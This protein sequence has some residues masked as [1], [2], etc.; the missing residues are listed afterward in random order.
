MF[1]PP[2]PMCLL[3]PNYPLSTERLILECYLALL[4]IIEHLSDGM[5]NSL[6]SVVLHIF[7]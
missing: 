3:S 1:L 7:N 6:D 4:Q 2:L 5:S